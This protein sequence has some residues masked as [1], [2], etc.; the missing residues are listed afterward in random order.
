MHLQVA[1]RQ[2]TER[3][4]RKKNSASAGCFCLPSD[5][6]HGMELTFLVLVLYSFVT[7]LFKSITQPQIQ[8]QIDHSNAIEM[9][10]R[11]RRR[12]RSLNKRIGPQKAHAMDMFSRRTAEHDDHYHAQRTAMVRSLNHINTI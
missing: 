1:I 4:R 12:L 9:L 2:K 10:S 8:I 5:L 3:R 7:E 6:R 11:R